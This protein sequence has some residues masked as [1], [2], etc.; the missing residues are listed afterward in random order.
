MY[1]FILSVQHGN[2]TMIGQVNAKSKRIAITRAILKYPNAAYI[3]VK[4]V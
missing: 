4:E 2:N 1:S 3:H